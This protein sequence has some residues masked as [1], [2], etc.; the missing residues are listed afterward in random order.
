MTLRII[1]FHPNC[2]YLRSCRSIIYTL[3]QTYIRVK[4][5]PVI[6]KVWD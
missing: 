3:V 2:Y 6:I 5:N 1:F 4:F